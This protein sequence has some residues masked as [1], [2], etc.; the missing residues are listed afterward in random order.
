MTLEIRPLLEMSAVV[1]GSKSLARIS[2]SR[3]SAASTHGICA[4]PTDR[5][6]LW[7]Q[8][9]L[10]FMFAP[11]ACQAILDL[12]VL[13]FGRVPQHLETRVPGRELLIVS[14]N[15][16]LADIRGLPGMKRTA[17]SDQMS[18]SR[19]SWDRV[20]SMSIWCS[21]RWP[22]SPRHAGPFAKACRLQRC[23]RKSRCRGLRETR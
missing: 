17:S 5:R 19:L 18:I 16:L 6:S 1:T 14:Q 7:R 10:G 11:L 15:G 4:V 20:N 8:L 13:V 23:G 12:N 21:F 22:P 9:K 2:T 3:R